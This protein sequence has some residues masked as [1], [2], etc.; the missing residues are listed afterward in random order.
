MFWKSDKETSDFLKSYFIGQTAFVNYEAPVS[1][2]IW[3]NGKFN[4]TSYQ[5]SCLRRQDWASD[6]VSAIVSNL[7]SAAEFRNVNALVHSTSFSGLAQVKQASGVC[8]YVRTIFV[9]RLTHADLLRKWFDFSRIWSVWGC[10]LSNLW[11]CTKAKSR[12]VALAKSNCPALGLIKSHNTLD[13]IY[14]SNNQIIEQNNERLLPLN[15]SVFL[16]K[17]M[18]PGRF[19]GDLCKHLF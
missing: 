11:P 6:A 17:S 12:N 10:V 5:Y 7:W 1:S 4:V 9:R 8:C 13:V 14:F 3:S 15:N 16:I 19:L 2:N 18:V